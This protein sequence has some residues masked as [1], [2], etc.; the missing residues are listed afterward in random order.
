M[1]YIQIH[2]ATDSSIYQE[3]VIATLYDQG[4]NGFETT[5]TGV[6]AFIDEDNYSERLVRELLKPLSL[7]F[8]AT[9]IEEQNWNELWENNFSPIIIDDFVA[10]RANFHQPITHVQHELIIT[11]KMSFGTGHHATTYSVIQLMQQINFQEKT[12]FDFGTGTGILAILAEKLGATNILA[13]DN[14]EWCINNSLENIQENNCHHITI[15]Q[16]DNAATSEKFDIVIANINLNIIIQN[17]ELLNKA[18]KPNGLVILSGLLTENETEI[19]LLAQK[20]QW[21]YIT[22]KEKDNYSKSKADSRC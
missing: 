17:F 9:V 20:F 13:V 16:A 8:T 1:N 22:T 6:N 12:V 14:D 15:Q 2:I 21:E 5:A 11:P 4:F 3:M 7:T 18:V 19:K 10:I